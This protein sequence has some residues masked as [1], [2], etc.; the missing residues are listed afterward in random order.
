MATALAIV[1]SG[2]GTSTTTVS[3]PTTSLA[4]PTTESEPGPF[5]FTAQTL[6]G[7]TIEGESLK[8]KDV[9]LWFWAPWCP[10]CLVEGKDQVAPALAE[11]PDGVQFVGIA[12]RSDDLAS[13]EEF[14]DWTG[15]GGV[16]HIV[17]VDGSIW[18]GFGVLLQPAFYF[19]NQDG[20]FDKAGS[21]LTTADLIAE[22]ET[23]TSS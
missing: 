13:M 15:T 9:V 8:H 3:N 11:L 7:E 22:F 10:I 21:G 2:C 17:D 14:L 20:T 12:G 1:L 16:T 6:E 18:A 4:P 5:D 23:L 19:V